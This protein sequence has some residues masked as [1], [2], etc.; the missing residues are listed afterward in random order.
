MSIGVMCPAKQVS[1]M[2]FPKPQK[3][4]ELGDKKKVIE[5]LQ[6]EWLCLRDF[7]ALDAP[8]LVAYLLGDNA[9]RQNAIADSFRSGYA[10]RALEKLWIAIQDEVVFEGDI[11]LYQARYDA[12]PT[13]ADAVAA[14]YAEGARRW[15]EQPM[16]LMPT[17]PER[18]HKVK[19]GQRWKSS[20]Y[21][22]LTVVGFMEGGPYAI[23]GNGIHKNVIM[24]LDE[25]GFCKNT[26][27]WKLFAE[28]LHADVE[29]PCGNP[30]GARRWREQP[31]YLKVAIGQRWKCSDRLLTVV[32]INTRFRQARLM[33]PDHAAQGGCY[34][35]LD[36]DGFCADRDRIAWEYVDA[37][38]PNPRKVER[39]PESPLDP[40]PTRVKANQ[41]WYQKIG[42]GGRQG[43]VIALV[44]SEELGRHALLEGYTKTFAMPLD[45]QDLPRDKENWRF[46]RIADLR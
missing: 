34:M 20:R 26:D 24:G 7:Q 1:R 30:E 4:T 37:G 9:A 12:I 33:G 36:V 5:F 23:L 27:D 38:D 15:R 11:E 14:T 10:E 42:E 46:D 28:L 16:Y 18:T 45:D 31:M 8:V 22:M 19:L 17:P 43:L 21:G 32:K 39:R 44:T 13:E 25:N 29:R 2:G 3:L 6:D 35:T 40:K 41:I